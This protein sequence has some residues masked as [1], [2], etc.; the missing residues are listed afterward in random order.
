ML[1]GLAI[2]ALIKFWVPIATGFGLVIKAYFAVKHGVQGWKTDI[3][4]WAD[5]LLNNHLNHIQAATETTANLLVEMRDA[6]HQSAMAVARVATDLRDHQEA[7]MV[8]QHQ[9]LTGLEV[10]KDRS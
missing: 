2:Y 9:I 8:V 10:L 4:S 3:T 1:N 5:A 6:N 7:S